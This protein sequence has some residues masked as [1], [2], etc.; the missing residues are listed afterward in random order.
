MLVEYYRMWDSNRFTI[1]LRSKNYSS[2]LT[3]ISCIRNSSLNQFL[4]QLTRR[5][6][7][8]EKSR[9]FGWEKCSNDRQID[10][11][12]F[13]LIRKRERIIRD[14]KPNSDT[15]RTVFLNSSSWIH[16]WI[17]AQR[18]YS[19]HYSAATADAWWYCRLM[20]KWISLLCSND[21]II[22]EIET[23][24]CAFFEWNSSITLLERHDNPRTEPSECWLKHKSSHGMAIDDATQKLRS[25][26]L[27]LFS[28]ICPF[29]FPRGHRSSERVTSPSTNF[30]VSQ[31]IFICRVW[32]NIKYKLIFDIQINRRSPQVTSRR[33]KNERVKSD[34]QMWWHQVWNMRKRTNRK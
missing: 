20:G 5:S 8:W 17:V 13:W 11:R 24:C 4:S 10:G 28:H 22:S 26:A 33:Q 32:L 25:I 34:E 3:C 23:D 31:F 21:I 7:W 12:N 29:K 16:C 14:V 9:P 15:R 1:F 6:F 30:L 2:H 19:L 27:K 18:S